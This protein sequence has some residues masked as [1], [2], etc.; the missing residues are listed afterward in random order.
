MYVLAYEVYAMCIC[1]V[2]KD[3][4]AQA[5]ARKSL[6]PTSEEEELPTSAG[7]RAGGH[8]KEGGAALSAHVS[9]R[10]GLA[11]RSTTRHGY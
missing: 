7:P 5:A 3:P 8:P 9:A 4:V 10:S 11:S 1:G 2:Y 6:L